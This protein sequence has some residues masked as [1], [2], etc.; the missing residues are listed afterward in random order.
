MHVVKAPHHVA[1]IATDVDVFCLRRE[2]QCIHRQVS[3]HKTP[4]FL[5]L[6]VGPELRRRQAEIDPGGYI[7][8]RHFVGFAVE[9]ELGDD[10][11]HPG[12]AGLGVGREDDVVVAKLKIVPVSRINHPHL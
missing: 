9:D 7:A 8:Y 1:A 3:F 5:R 6:E 2:H 4:M 11:L 10:L 12:D